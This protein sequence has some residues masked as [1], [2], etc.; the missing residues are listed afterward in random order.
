[1][2][3]TL[4]LKVGLLAAFLSSAHLPALAQQSKPPG[5]PPSVANPST[6]AGEIEG[7]ARLSESFPGFDFRFVPKSPSVYV[8]LFSRFGSPF[9]EQGEIRIDGPGVQVPGGS[10]MYLKTGT[11]EGVEVKVNGIQGSP[12]QVQI[13]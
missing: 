6:V 10:T 2:K 13:F 11:G 7:H 1:M 5:G 4:L 9:S 8:L 3:S 12:L